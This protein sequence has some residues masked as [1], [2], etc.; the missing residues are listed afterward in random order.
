VSRLR[1]ALVMMVLA[2]VG[3]AVLRE[4]SDFPAGYMGL[5]TASESELRNHDLAQLRRGASR[6]LFPFIPGYA[7]LIAVLVGSYLWRRPPVL[8]A[9]KGLSFMVVAAAVIGV[10]AD[11]VETVRFRA[12]LDRLIRG[13]ALGER[14]ISIT[15]GVANVKNIALLAM[16]LALLTVINY[17]EPASSHPCRDDPETTDE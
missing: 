17:S 12:T 10:V 14:E 3:L 8:R 16:V 4:I 15:Q 5:Q 6:D 7:A 2:G 11:V 13:Q 1:D 9:A